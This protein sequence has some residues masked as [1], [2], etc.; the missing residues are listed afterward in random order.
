P[1]VRAPGRVIPL[2]LAETAMKAL[3]PEPEK[4]FQTAREFGDA[5]EDYLRGEASRQLV[6]VARSELT[7]LENA[8][9][10]PN[11]IPAELYSG[12]STVVAEFAQ[13]LELWPA[14]REAAAG[15]SRARITF[16][17]YALRH[18][19]TSIAETQVR[20]LRPEDP[21][22]VELRKMIDKVHADLRAE[23]SRKK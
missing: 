21:A 19:D 22:V 17:R 11:V 20:D 2:A 9:T 12:F 5:I 1:H 14:N 23:T 10:Y 4:R 16:A 6:D 8:I 18:G 7:R 13:A 15:L 3:A